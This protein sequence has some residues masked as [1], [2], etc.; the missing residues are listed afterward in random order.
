MQ[1]GENESNVLVKR[2]LSIATNKK[3]FWRRMVEK[4]ISL[5]DFVSCGR[6]CSVGAPASKPA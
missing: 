6:I 2:L 1:N 5:L 4:S 3:K